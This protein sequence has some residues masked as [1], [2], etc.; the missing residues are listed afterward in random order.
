M[1][2][3]LSFFLPFLFPK[4][5]LN[6]VCV[7]FAARCVSYSADGEMLAGG[8][9]NG[10]FLLLLANSLKIWAKKRD[11]SVAIQDIRYERESERVTEK[12]KQPLKFISREVMWHFMAVGCLDRKLLAPQCNLFA[13][14]YLNCELTIDSCIFS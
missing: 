11:R 9:K 12:E 1:V 14:L 5:L 6:K 8:L 10:E 13:L 2:L 7:G 3:I 4:K